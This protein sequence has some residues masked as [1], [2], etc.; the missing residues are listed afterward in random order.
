MEKRKPLIAG[1]WKMYKTAEEAGATAHQLV[2]LVGA[3]SDIDIMIAP[4][5]TALESVATAIKNSPLELG[6]QNLFWENEGAYTGEISAPMLVSLGCQYC[7]IGHSER[8]QYFDETD[9]TVNKKIRAA[10]QAGLKPV[11]CI[12]ETEEQREAGQTFS[13]L[14][15]QFKKGVEGFASDQLNSLIIAYEPV[16][17]IG[18]GKTATNDQAQEAHQ[19]IRSLI[20]DSLGNTIFKSTRILYGGSVKPENISKLMEMPDIDG[21]LVGGA[22]LSAESF[23][24]IVNFRR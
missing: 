12:G 20:K 19:F 9:E 10:I 16:W 2:E 3:V 6:A 14:D 18:T 23:N 5:F 21:A 7:I 15:K 11:F 1:N 8:R 17:A 22:S 4:P 24:K 13:V